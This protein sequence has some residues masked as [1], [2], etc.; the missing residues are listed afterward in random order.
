MKRSHALT[1][2]LALGATALYTLGS[3]YSAARRSIEPDPAE[4]SPEV[5]EKKLAFWNLEFEVDEVLYVHAD[6]NGYVF[7]S[8]RDPEG[9]CGTPWARAT[10]GTHGDALILPHE[11][12]RSRTGAHG[13]VVAR[14]IEGGRW[15]VGAV[16]NSSSTEV[17]QGSERFN[18]RWKDLLEKRVGSAASSAPDGAVRSP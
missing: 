17:T 11:A 1:L 15:L 12:F 14:P 4:T 18:R 16:A 2:G 3:V 8:K 13:F 6:L 10:G 5:L 9:C 7:T